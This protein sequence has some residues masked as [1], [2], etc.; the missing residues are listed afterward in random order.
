[1]LGPFHPQN[2]SVKLT[3]DVVNRFTVQERLLNDEVDMAVMGLIEDTHD[4]EVAEVV[5]E[6]G[7]DDEDSFLCDERHG[8]AGGSGLG[9]G[10]IRQPLIVADWARVAK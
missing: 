3:L 9:A 7:G 5:K 6:A 4:L 8:V 1:M 10:E 2:H